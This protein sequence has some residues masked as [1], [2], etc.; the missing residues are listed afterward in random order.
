MGIRESR[1]ELSKLLRQ[2]Q[3]DIVNKFHNVLIIIPI[4]NEACAGFI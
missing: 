2:G 1:C 4:S 3:F